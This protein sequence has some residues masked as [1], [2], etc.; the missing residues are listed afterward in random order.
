MCLLKVLCSLFTKGLMF[1]P[2]MFLKFFE[3][4]DGLGCLKGSA[5]FGF[6]YFCCGLRV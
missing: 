2:L 6:L 4:E 3:L 5:V 1:L